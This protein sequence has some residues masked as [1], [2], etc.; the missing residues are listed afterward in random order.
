MVNMDHL[1]ESLY[2]IIL[3]SVQIQNYT[4]PVQNFTTYYAELVEFFLKCLKRVSLYRH[5]GSG[6]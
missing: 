4:M 3:M 5:K 6:K 1:L 2:G